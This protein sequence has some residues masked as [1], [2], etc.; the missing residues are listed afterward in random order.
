MRKTALAVAGVL[1]T[2]SLA[3]AE[4][5]P[6][7]RRLHLAQVEA[8]SYLVNDW[9]KFQENYLPL[10]VGDDDPSTAWNDGVDGSPV[11][12]WLRLHVTP[13]AG[14]SQVRLRVRNGYQKN[15]K[16][17]AANARLHR[18]TVVLLPSGVKKDLDLA[19]AQGWQD[20]LVTQPPGPLEAVELRV[21]SIYEG[22]KYD[23]LAISDVQLQVTS[24]ASE[25]PAFEK[26]RF[27]KI[28]TWKRERLAAAH[29]FRTAAA[30]AMPIAGQYTVA[31]GAEARD[32]DFDVCKPAPS[33]YL[34]QVIVHAQGNP[35][36]KKHAP[37]LA[38]GLDL[39]RA[40]FQGL[41]PVRAVARVSRP[42]PAVDGLCQPPVDTCIE[43]PCAQALPMPLGGQLGFLQAS[44]VGTLAAK[45]VPP[46]ADALAMK[47]AVCK[48]RAGATWAWAQ[49]GPDGS[50]LEAL[51]LFQCGLVM[52]REGYYP[53]ST[54]QL[55][56]YDGEGRVELAAGRSYAAIYEWRAG[57]SGPVLARGWRTGGGDPDAQ[58][59]EATALAK[60]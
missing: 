60:R 32:G 33:C 16:I 4:G 38:R 52:G 18:V 23:D 53:S 9:N 3:R 17:F 20:L 8:S 22:A 47:P 11:G 40:G 41:A 45:D 36:M 24:T 31:T 10:Y 50:A 6:V 29:L 44:T 51:V 14:S 2:V 12:Q 13:L 49:R 5:P 58:I 43:N 19:D 56:V 25:N 55:L 26:Q 27:D 48:T 42:L 15:A 39:A 57:E 54:L 1:A 35:A 37:A 28:L 30:K 21:Q 46:L 34:A 59:E 7:E